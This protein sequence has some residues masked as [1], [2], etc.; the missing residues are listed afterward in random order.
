M[1]GCRASF[2]TT[3]GERSLRRLRSSVRTGAEESRIRVARWVIRGERDVE[4]V[5]PVRF[6]ER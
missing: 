6:W 1:C 5:A 2:T 3:C 4:F